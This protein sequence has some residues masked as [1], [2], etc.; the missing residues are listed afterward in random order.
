MAL[1]RKTRG[2]RERRFSRR[3]ALCASALRGPTNAEAFH[4]H[5]MMR[6]R[7]R[8]TYLGHASVKGKPTLRACGARASALF[9]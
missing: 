9:P 5:P 6:A 3:D 4:F 1:R 8:L 7:G 2:W